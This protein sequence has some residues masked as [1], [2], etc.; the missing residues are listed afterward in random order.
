MYDQYGCLDRKAVDREVQKF[1]FTILFYELARYDLDETVQSI[2]TI[3]TP[4]DVI[5]VVL[6]CRLFR[7]AALVIVISDKSIVDIYLLHFNHLPKKL[8]KRK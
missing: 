6:R 8:K 5:V 4:S 3:G 1:F 7:P 2:H